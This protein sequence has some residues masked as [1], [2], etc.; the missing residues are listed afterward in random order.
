MD[1]YLD[2]EPMIRALSEEPEAFEIRRNCLRHRPSR[3]WLIF[4]S[5]GNARI[6]ARCSCTELPISREQSEELREAVG[7]WEATYWHPLLAREAAERRI[8]EIN[9]EFAEHLRPRGKL[10]RM[11]DAALAFVGI[12]APDP[13]FDIDPSLPED[14]DLHTRPVPRREPEREKLSLA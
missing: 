6:M 14:A 9:R 3:H 1:Y 13:V 10:Q 11:F 8:A 2:A 5:D 7:I 4:D 12:A